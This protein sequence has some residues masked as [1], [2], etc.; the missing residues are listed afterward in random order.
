MRGRQ[1]CGRWHSPCFR[2]L[3][4]PSDKKSLAAP[5]ISPDELE[6]AASISDKIQLP[7]DHALFHVK[8]DHDPFQ[9]NRG[10]SSSPE[11]VYDVE[12]FMPA[13]FL[14]VRVRSIHRPPPPYSYL[15]SLMSITPCALALRIRMFMIPATCGV[16]SSREVGLTCPF[17]HGKERHDLLLGSE[18]AMRSIISCMVCPDP[19]RLFR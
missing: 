9:T 11:C 1:R 6:V 18:S 3:E 7:A 8:P 19:A 4:G 12:A 14:L 5:E 13:P 16:S 10:N 2:N 17:V 15:F